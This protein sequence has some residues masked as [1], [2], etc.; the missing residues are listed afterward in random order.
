M[1][2]KR[3]FVVLFVSLI[4]SSSFSS[5][6]CSLSQYPE[7]LVA[8]YNNNED[9]PHEPDGVALV[10]NIKFKK[11]TPEYVFH[12]QVIIL[13]KPQLW[14]MMRVMIA[15]RWRGKVSWALSFCVLL[16]CAR[17]V[18]SINSQTKEKRTRSL[19]FVFLFCSSEFH[20][21]KLLLYLSG[22]TWQPEFGCIQ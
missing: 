17:L 1:F 4:T 15:G 12:C 18:A 19:L 10:W 11:A 5:S 9:A 3:L 16:F 14:N 20:T 8:S 21:Q 7:L 6:S 13:I 2:V 22:F